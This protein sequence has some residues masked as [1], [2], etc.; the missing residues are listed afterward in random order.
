VLVKRHHDPNTRIVE[1][2]SEDA[3]IEV[4]GP[5]S[6]PLSNDGL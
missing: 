6:L 2:G 5:D 1:R 4:H 3:H